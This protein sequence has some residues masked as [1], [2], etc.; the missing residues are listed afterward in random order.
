[1]RIDPIE[2]LFPLGDR[3]SRQKL[4]LAIYPRLKEPTMTRTGSTIAAVL[5]VSWLACAFCRG[6]EPITLKGHTRDVRAV[7]WS[8]DGKTLASASEDM[9]VKLWEAVTGK[10][11]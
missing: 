8:P 3:A 9:T 1:M 7:S 10:E 2:L 4:R 5:A 11:L 6:S